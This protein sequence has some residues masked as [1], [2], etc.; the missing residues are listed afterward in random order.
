MPAMADAAPSPPTG[1]QQHV[2]DTM[3]A[4]TTGLSLPAVLQR[5]IQSAVLLVDAEYGAL[6]VIGAGGAL[7]EFITT[8]GEPGLAEAIGHPPEGL[9][10]LGLLIADPRPLR[11]RDL[12]EHPLAH[13]FPPQHP[14]MQSFLGVPITISASVYGNLYLCEKRGGG[15]FSG[16]DERLVV[17]LAAVAAVAI[18]NARLHD[19]LQQLAVIEDRERIARDLHDKVIQRLFA[20]GMSLQGMSRTLADVSAVAKIDQAVDDL[21]AVIAEIRSSIFDLEARP[22]SSPNLSAAVLDLVDT[23][24]RSSG[25]EPDVRIEG[26][27][28]E[29]VGV[30]LGDD[31][32]A[33]T[34]ELLTN[35]VRH[36]GATQVEVLIEVGVDLL[37]EVRDDGTG[38]D[39]SSSRAG[40][41]IPNVRAR[42]NAWSGR[43]DRRDLAGATLLAPGP[44]DP[45]AF[46]TFG[47]FGPFRRAA[48]G[49]TLTTMFARDFVHVH[50]PFEHVA[51]RFAGE[52]TW[53]EPIVT[54]ALGHAVALH[55]GP[56][57]R[58]RGSLAKQR[59]RC[60]RGSL[61]VRDGALVV[62]LTWTFDLDPLALSPVESDLTVAPIDQ[63]Q[64]M[65]TVEA[66]L[67]SSVHT[68]PVRMQHL[69]EAVLRGFLLGLA[70]IVDPERAASS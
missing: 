49:G 65:L 39:P 19:R 32:L 66:R 10:I 12:M 15:E 29:R 17:S 56:E 16:D 51:P 41:G 47:T 36:S 11:L 53:L 23:T 27:L 24:L 8:G 3:L 4:V 68:Q 59:A 57:L 58:S 37:L 30:A 63:A 14:R 43:R 1:P 61:R 33:S 6:G 20:T 26:P 31:L 40:H 45:T 35:V 70:K 21:D 52:A 55:G 67:R 9:G 46:G 7:A 18:D 28:S 5:V 42:A 25:I 48:P 60:T 69:V 2:L 64:C 50:Q 38:L 34:R 22:A 13:G 62:P 54:D 44:S